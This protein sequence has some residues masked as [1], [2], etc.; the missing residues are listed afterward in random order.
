M[1]S[2]YMV[3]PVCAKEFQYAGYEGDKWVEYPEPWECKSCK[4]SIVV[5]KQKGYG[6]KAL[7]HK[8]MQPDG[9]GVKHWSEVES[10]IELEVK[11]G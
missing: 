2:G 3:C 9:N 11:D 8:Q 10:D 5:D 6:L 4:N 1:T 7:P